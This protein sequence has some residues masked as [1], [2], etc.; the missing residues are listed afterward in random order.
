MAVRACPGVPDPLLKTL[1][2]FAAGV[3]FLFTDA[4]EKCYNRVVPKDETIFRCFAPMELSIR[5]KKGQKMDHI[6][7]NIFQNVLSAYDV[8]AYGVIWEPD[9]MTFVPD[10]STEVTVKC[11][12]GD[13]H[14]Y[15]AYEVH[16][17]KFD[18]DDRVIGVMN[19]PANIEK[20]ICT[21]TSICEA[22]EKC[23]SR[24]ASSSKE[25]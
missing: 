1:A 25:D 16:V 2:A 20:A 7:L 19:E 21:S 6:T 11:D 17:V 23:E 9:G 14:I 13:Y 24:F 3:F 22:I 4:I 10:E 12:N 8:P 18:E 15:N 5:E